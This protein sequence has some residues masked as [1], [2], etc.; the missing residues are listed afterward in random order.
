MA[1]KVARRVL[2]HPKIAKNFIQFRYNL[3][4]S[5]ISRPRN[6]CTRNDMNE[7]VFQSTINKQ[8]SI[9]QVSSTRRF[10]NKYP[11]NWKIIL[12]S[13]G[14]CIYFYWA[15]KNKPIFKAIDNIDLNELIKKDSVYSIMYAE[16]ISE[17]FV[18]Y[19]KHLGLGMIR[20]DKRILDRFNCNDKQ[21]FIIKDTEIISIQDLFDT[22]E[23]CMSINFKIIND[24]RTVI[25]NV[26]MKFTPK[27]EILPVAG[28]LPDEYASKQKTTVGT[29][30]M[31]DVNGKDN[32]LRVYVD[33]VIG[34]TQEKLII[35]DKIWNED[36]YDEDTVGS[37][38]SDQEIE[39]S[40]N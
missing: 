13:A 7:P 25:G 24:S 5:L 11:W 8:G 14:I 18:W 4:R 28:S 3:Q 34:R 6:F 37:W 32:Q 12:I 16:S 10:R 29:F 17:G 22:D 23:Q 26:Y 30:M 2:P 38:F 39:I 40:R 35:Y 31:K 9:K 27:H 36:D 15:A 21:L 19:Y 33:V 1:T 20:Q